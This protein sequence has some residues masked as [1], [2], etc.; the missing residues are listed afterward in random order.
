M[1]F[2]FSKKSDQVF[3]STPSNFSGSDIRIG[4]L[5]KKKDSVLREYVRALSE[6]DLKFLC[7]RLSHTYGRRGG[8]VPHVVE[9]VQESAEMDRLF[10]S[11]RDADHLY[12]LVDEL[13]EYSERE[14]KRRIAA[15][16]EAQVV[17]V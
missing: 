1:S 11:A 3:N 15:E 6:E 5:M 4:N 10:G 16:R 13:Q 17:N 8:D 12:D 7:S 9:F 14:I 2:G